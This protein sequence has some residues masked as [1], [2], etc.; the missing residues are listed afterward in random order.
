[1]TT[2]VCPITNIARLAQQHRYIRVPGHAEEPQPLGG[3][4]S[5]HIRSS[6]CV[7]NQFQTNVTN[8]SQDCV[9]PGVSS[10]QQCGGHLDP[11]LSK[12]RGHCTSTFYIKTPQRFPKIHVTGSLIASLWISSKLVH[13]ATYFDLCDRPSLFRQFCW[14]KWII[15]LLRYYPPI[16]SIPHKPSK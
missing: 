8:S 1:M 12:T 7:S 15:I 3:S 13:V 14:W 10:S 4:L 11:Q 16:R 9:L 6:G 2:H 5:F